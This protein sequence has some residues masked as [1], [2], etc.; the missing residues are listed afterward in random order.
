MRTKERITVMDLQK[1]SDTLYNLIAVDYKLRKELLKDVV[2]HSKEVCFLLSIG[3]YYHRTKLTPTLHGKTTNYTYQLHTLLE[4]QKTWG[5]IG[6]QEQVVLKEILNPKSTIF[7]SGVF[8]AYG[9]KVYTLDEI[10]AELGSTQHLAETYPYLLVAPPSSRNKLPYYTITRSKTGAI[11]YNNTPQTFPKFTLENNTTL[12]IDS[13]MEVVGS[14]TQAL[15]DYIQGNSRYFG[16]LSSE[17]K[18]SS[19]IADIRRIVNSRIK[20]V[21]ALVLYEGKLHTLKKEL[22]TYSFK[23]VDYIITDDYDIEGVWITHNGKA[24]AV[25]VPKYDMH[26]IAKYEIQD[27]LVEVRCAKLLN[28]KL[29]QITFSKFIIKGDE[30]GGKE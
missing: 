15:G 3:I 16:E 30:P 19:S 10:K 29:S 26:R 25:R 24:Y 22:P 23:I 6:L 21:V 8:Y 14:G 18:Y 27:T 1:A 7:D 9:V 5:S 20:E 28:G 4:E 2:E 12:L 17:F 13:Y 11:K